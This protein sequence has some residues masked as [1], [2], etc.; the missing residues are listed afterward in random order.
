[1]ILIEASHTQ[2]G[3]VRLINDDINDII[4][5]DST[6]QLVVFVEYGGG[7]QVIPLED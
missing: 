3:V 4:D 7:Y 6:Q 2:Q 5:G 1:M